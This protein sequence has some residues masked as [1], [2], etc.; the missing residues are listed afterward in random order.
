MW[1]QALALIIALDAVGKMAP[2][3]SGI[4][5]PV[6]ESV[7]RAEANELMS[8]PTG[9]LSRGWTS[10]GSLDRSVR[11]P[12]RG[13]GYAFF[14][15]IRGRETYYGTAEMAGFV[16]RVGARMKAADPD[17][18]VGIGNVSLRKGGR[19]RWH[20]SHQTGR[21]VDVAMFLI[22]RKG[23]ARNPQDFRSFGPD[24]KS[25]DG[26]GMTF[27]V[28]R[29]LSLVLAMIEDM[30]VGVQW[31]FCAEYLKQAMLEAARTRGVD[32]ELLERLGRVLHQPTDALPHDDHFHVRLYCSVEDRLY[33]CLDRPPLWSWVDRGDAAYEARVSA[34]SRI[35]AHEALDLRVDAVGWLK[36]IRARP[37]VPALVALLN[38]EEE[39]LA[40]ASLDALR[41]IGDPA[42][43][44]GIL[45]ALSRAKDLKWASR[46]F[47]TLTAFWTH[48]NLAVGTRFLASP[49]ELLHTELH[50]ADHTD[51]LITS[52]GLLER[53]G[54]L[55]EAPMLLPLLDHR[56]RSV[57]TAA[58]KALRRITAHSSSPKV[59]SSKGRRHDRAVKWWRK[60]LADQE[61]W[62][63]LLRL[64]LRRAGHKVGDDLT[65]S[66]NVKRLI[67]A[68]DDRRAYV[69]HNAVR[70][71]S[72]VTGHE[73]E[74]YF[75][76]RRALKRHWERWLEENGDSWKER[77]P[78]APAG[79]QGAP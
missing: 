36:R 52:A 26:R 20:R 63:G 8:E 55:K 1:A 4:T 58:E 61:D 64:G 71:L 77:P 53:F 73:V 47:R 13:T 29:N 54:T 67:K 5:K 11:V 38:S 41:A 75:R 74:P 46:L 33:G 39:K 28:A 21:D 22:D 24:L 42:A 37:A 79:I 30:D 14:K 43:I 34:L 6:G 3:P 62:H 76:S 23:K 45:E 44:P 27:D 32:D 65:T 59:A 56:R 17:S 16:A 9:S 48:D 72:S 31:I 49:Q 40:R 78:Q 69:S 51:F 70:L 66:K 50:A 10:S 18:V 7:T 12:L 2:L 25:R 60:L 19:S 15:H 35:L 57:Q 68:V